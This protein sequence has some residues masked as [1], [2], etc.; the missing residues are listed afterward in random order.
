MSEKRSARARCS[1]KGRRAI[2]ATQRALYLLSEAQRRTR[3]FAAAEVTARRLIALDPRALGGPRQLAQ[4]FRDQRE[5]QKI[6]A[7]LEPI[8][9]ARLGAADAADLA[10]DTFRA[11]YFD[12]ASAYERAAAVRQGD[13]AADAGAHPVADRPA[14]GHPARAIAAGSRQGRR[15]HQDAAGGGGEVPQGACGEAVARVRARA[16]AEVQRGRRRCSGR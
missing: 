2:R 9:T 4:I 10:S 6:V 11:T 14:R 8:V 16:G 1:K 7:L 3:D 5:H 13:R 15:R 12:L